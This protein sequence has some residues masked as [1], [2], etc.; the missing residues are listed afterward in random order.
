MAT[1]KMD[2][3][4]KPSLGEEAIEGIAYV[5]NGVGSVLMFSGK[6]SIIEMLIAAGEHT[7]GK[8]QW[9]EIMRRCPALTEAKNMA[10][11][12]TV[13]DPM[14]AMLST[15]ARKKNAAANASLSEY[16]INE[17]VKALSR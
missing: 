3:N 8:V 11:N 13:A 15:Q 12:V 5:F 17:A 7:V 14:V 4:D 10:D 1:L 16:E 6:E 2:L 9:G